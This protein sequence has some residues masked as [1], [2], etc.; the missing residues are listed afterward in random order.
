MYR[1]LQ[2]SN[3]TRPYSKSARELRLKPKPVHLTQ[4]PLFLLTP[5]HRSGCF[6]RKG[7]LL[8]RRKRN[9]QHCRAPD[10]SDW[11]C[12]W[13]S[14]KCRG[15]GVAWDWMRH[16]YWPLLVYKYLVNAWLGDYHFSFL[17]F[18]FLLLLSPPLLFLVDCGVCAHMCTHVHTPVPLLVYTGVRTGCQ[19]SPSVSFTLSPSDRVSLWIWDLVCVR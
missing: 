7:G 1:S 12:T 16:D 5:L 11:N 2:L 15:V 3:Y 4:E 14:L 10:T 6:Y 9:E 8:N 13:V 19:F 18:L 17:L